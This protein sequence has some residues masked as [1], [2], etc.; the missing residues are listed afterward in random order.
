MRKTV[1]RYGLYGTILM[2]VILLVTFLVFR[3]NENWELQEI[4]GYVSIVLSLLLVYFGIRQ[5]RDQYNGGRLSFGKGFTIGTLITLFPSVAFGLFTWIEMSVLDPG[6]SDRYYNHYVEQVKKTT[7]P[8]KLQAVLTQMQG[9][10]EMFSSP[11]AQF[12]LMFL[13]VFIIGIIITV[14]SSLILR[15]NKPAIA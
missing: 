4:I 6:F 15:R 9:Q 2:L 13:T 5:W 10:K 14:I 3:N 11:L 8:E 7:P 12:F 1:L